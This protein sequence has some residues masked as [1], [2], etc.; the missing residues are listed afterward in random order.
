MMRMDRNEEI[1]IVGS[2]LHSVAMKKCEGFH[3]ETGLDSVD[4]RWGKAE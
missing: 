1:A 2:E 3:E 4:Y